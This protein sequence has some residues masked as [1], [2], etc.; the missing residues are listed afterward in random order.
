MGLV[1]LFGPHGKDLRLPTQKVDNIEEQ[2]LPYLEEAAHVIQ[3]EQGV[4]LAAPQIGVPYAWYIDTLLKVYINPEIV[5]N[6]EGEEERVFEGCLSVPERR[7]A[8]KRMSKV[9]LSFTNIDGEH[10]LLQFSKLSAWVAQHECDHLNGI[11]VCDHG[12]RVYKGDE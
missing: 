8:T 9:G 10:E 5:D 3:R 1:T 12:E 2:V 7:Y 11:L 4:G 6:P